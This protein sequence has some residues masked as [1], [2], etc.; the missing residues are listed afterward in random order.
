[1][2]AKSFLPAG[3]LFIHLIICT[4]HCGGKVGKNV[5]EGIQIAH[6]AQNQQVL[7]RFGL[8]R[9]LVPSIILAIV[10]PTSN[11]LLLGS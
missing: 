10:A 7:T 2:S 9:I 6:I 8:N 1:M 11:H 5:L 3:F 4:Y